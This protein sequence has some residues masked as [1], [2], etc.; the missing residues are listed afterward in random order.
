MYSDSLSFNENR[1]CILST[2]Y[3]IFFITP[4][5]KKFRKINLISI[6]SV[7]FTLLRSHQQS[8]TRRYVLLR[9]ESLR[10]TSHPPTSSSF[11]STGTNTRVRMVIKAHTPMAMWMMVTKTRRGIMKKVIIIF[12][13]WIRQRIMTAK[14]LTDS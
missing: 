12:P 5:T 14:P 7:L 2:A 9:A 3:F 10:S 8:Y 1:C 4:N 13:S 11:P 6:Y